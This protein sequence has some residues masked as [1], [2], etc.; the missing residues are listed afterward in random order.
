MFPFS[1]MASLL[2]VFIW[3]HGN[4][5][6][7]SSILLNADLSENVILDTK[8]NKVESITRVVR[9]NNA[10]LNLFKT[11]CKWLKLKVCETMFKQII[12][13]CLIFGYTSNAE[14]Y[15]KKYLVLFW[16]LYSN[17]SLWAKNTGSTGFIYLCLLVFIIYFSSFLAYQVI[18]LTV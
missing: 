15:M 13:S 11:C 12:Q 2:I 7:T 9:A 14:S 1:K 4:F 6:T 5:N 8:S 17:C 16:I 18:E 3:N 10:I